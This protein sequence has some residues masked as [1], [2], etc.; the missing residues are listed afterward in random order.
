MVTQKLQ[1]LLVFTV[2]KG[3]TWGSC[4]GEAYNMYIYILHTM[5]TYIY[6]Y[7]YIYTYTACQAL[8]A[9]DHTQSMES[10]LNEE[11]LTKTPSSTITGKQHAIQSRRRETPEHL[12]KGPL[13]MLPLSLLQDYYPL[14]TASMSFHVSLAECNPR[15]CLAHVLSK[16]RAPDL[17]KHAAK[18]RKSEHDCPNAQRRNNRRG[19]GNRHLQNTHND[20]TYTALG[21]MLEC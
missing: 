15:L 10:R 11:T 20:G 7:I 12:G 5:Y 14:Y 8:E 4:G 3:P 21:S 19:G 13:P 6:T 9:T 16:P 2:Q 1:F 17:G 18:A